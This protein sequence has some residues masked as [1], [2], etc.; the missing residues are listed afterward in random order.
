MKKK[1]KNSVQLKDELF[2]RYPQLISCKSGFIKAYECL[3]NKIGRASCRERVSA[4]V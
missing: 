2:E 4:V 1:E 3:K